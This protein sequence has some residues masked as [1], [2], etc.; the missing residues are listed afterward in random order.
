[1]TRL[2]AACCCAAL[3]TT[4]VLLLTQ[5]YPALPAWMLF[6]TWACFF[7]LG[8]GEHPAAAFRT[9]V[10]HIGFGVLTAWLTALLLL[11]SPWNEGLLHA[12]WGPVVI[13]LVIGALVRL[14]VVGYFAVTP[15]IIYGYASVWAFLST[16]GH[17]SLQALQSLSMQNVI[18]AL[19]P[20]I[21]IGASMGVLNARLVDWLSRSAS[22]AAV[23]QH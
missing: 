8:G 2:N 15:A 3:L 6:I 17:F 19:P 5:G 11:A 9:V 10:T 22:P 21:L 20:C 1:M 14:G 18:I 23:H 16:G 13:G 12:L 4:I 7:H